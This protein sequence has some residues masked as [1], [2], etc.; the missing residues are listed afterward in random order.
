MKNSPKLD[1]LMVMGAVMDWNKEKEEWSF[2]SIIP[3]YSGAIVMGKARAKAAT[4]LHEH[5]DILLVTGGKDTHPNTQAIHSRSDELTKLIQDMGVP[6]NK[7][8]PMGKGGNTLENVK[9][10]ALYLKEH[11]EVLKENRIG[12]LCI[13][14]QYERAKAM[15]DKEYAENPFFKEH[16]VEVV[17]FQAEEVLESSVSEAQQHHWKRWGTA[18]DQKVVTVK[19]PSTGE[20]K[21]GKAGDIARELETKGLADFRSNN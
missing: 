15:F 13:S 17:W 16:P 9:D 19:D 3:R 20:D 7:V 12:V 6:Q 8:I 4:E 2:P 5:A 10:L 14:Y 21:T 1:A 18:V 11:S